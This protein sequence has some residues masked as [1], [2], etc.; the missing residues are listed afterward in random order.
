MSAVNTFRNLRARRVIGVLVVA[1]AVLAGYL[2]LQLYNKLTTNTVVAYFPEANALYAGD[3]VQIMG[4]RVGAVDKIE[5]AGDKMMVTFHYENKYKVPAN[6]S[7]V[8]VNPTLV[9]SRNIQLEPPY[10]GGPVMGDNAVIPIERTQV[11]TEWDQLSQSVANVINKLGPTPEQPKGPFGD[12]IESFADGL[13]GKGKQINTT[14]NSLSRALTALNEG[15]GDFFAVV[16]SLAQ[17]VNAL[18][19]D[20][21]QF[22]A[23]NQNLAQF[24]DKLTGSDRELATAIQQFDS[25]LSTLRPF[26]DK[27]RGVLTSDIDNLATLTNTLVQPDPLNG[28]ET[29]LHVLPTLETNLSQIYHPTHGA[30]MSIPAIPNFANPMQFVCSMIQAGSRLGYQDS[31]ELCAQYLAPVLD[32]IKFNY[33]PFGLNLFSTAETLPKEVAYSEPRLQPPNGYK[34][35]TVPGIWVPDTPLSHRNTQPGWVVAPGMQGQQVGPITAGLLT[36]DSLAELMGGPD[37]APPQ[38]GLQT[39]PGPPNAY[40]ENP[41]LPPIGVRAPQVPIPPPAPGPGVIPGPVA[42]TPPPVAAVSAGLGS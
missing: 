21:Q 7:A 9:A 20:D 25:L 33:L 17:F 19:K 6:A 2:G 13:A 5:P 4:V 16:H 32:A 27:N 29:A 11:P 10:K 40:D 42:P 15:R 28:L 24:T 31:A 1:L 18:H 22:V 3:K 37:I 12:A 34:D 23:L 35:T 14:L 30:V 26:L 38:S 39:P 41:V 8:I 36:P